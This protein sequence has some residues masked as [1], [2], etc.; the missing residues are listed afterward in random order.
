MIST[1]KN[2]LFLQIEVRKISYYENLFHFFE[3]KKLNAL[4]E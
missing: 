3:N 4:F 2:E 1:S